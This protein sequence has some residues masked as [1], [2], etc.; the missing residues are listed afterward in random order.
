MS[1]P[2]PDPRNPIIPDLLPHRILCLFTR[3]N[4]RTYERYGCYF[5]REDCTVFADGR[6]VDGYPRGAEWI[7]PLPA[8]TIG[9]TD[10]RPRPAPAPCP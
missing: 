6:K 1:A 3:G 7:D 4:G 9:L 10:P 5:P 8:A 2:D